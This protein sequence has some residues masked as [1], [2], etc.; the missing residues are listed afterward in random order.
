MTDKAEFIRR[1]RE[2][3]EKRRQ[4]FLDNLEKEKEIG[5]DKPGPSDEA[6]D[7]DEQIEQVKPRGLR[8][9][10]SA[11][12]QERRYK[13][14]RKHKESEERKEELEKASQRKVF[15]KKLPRKEEEEY[16]KYRQHRK[17]VKAERRRKVREGLTK[18]SETARKV[19]ERSREMSEG[20]SSGLDVADFGFKPR[21]D[22]RDPV[23]EMFMLKSPS[24][25]PTGAPIKPRMGGGAPGRDPLME[26]FAMPKGPDP[27][28]RD[29]LLDMFV[30]PKG[31]I[32]FGMD[33]F[34]AQPQQTGKKRK[35]SEPDPLLQFFKFRL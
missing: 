19:G 9:K 6:Q 7:V 2:H 28:K 22:G 24:P 34:G 14:F 27:T 18:F 1:E 12:R 20:F 4:E 13:Q 3:D 5:K 8:E 35:K 31:N 11:F 29:P 30:I 16:E 10:V 21:T 33:S 17:D 26:M 25:E 32:N 15:G 23:A